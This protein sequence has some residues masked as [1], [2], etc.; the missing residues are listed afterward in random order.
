[1]RKVPKSVHSKGIRCEDSFAGLD[2]AHESGVSVFI[3]VGD[4]HA[5]PLNSIRTFDDEGVIGVVIEH[6]G[7]LWNHQCET[8][9]GYDSYPRQHLRF[10]A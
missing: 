10:E 4:L 2:T 1:M 3:P 8:G 7:G 6:Q 5:L 9:I